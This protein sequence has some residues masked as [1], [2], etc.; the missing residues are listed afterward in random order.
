MLQISKI[1]FRRNLPKWL[2]HPCSQTTHVQTSDKPQ[3]I[4][5]IY[6]ILVLYG[7]VW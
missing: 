6:T 3:T 2:A 5:G 4:V 1:T 7:T